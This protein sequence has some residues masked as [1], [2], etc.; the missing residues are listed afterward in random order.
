MVGIK[1]MTMP[2]TCDDCPMS[3]STG[4]IFCGEFIDYYDDGYRAT[5][6]R[7]PDCPIVE[8]E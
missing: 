3:S 2:K 4:C 1:E 6:T 7:M 5:E 8:I